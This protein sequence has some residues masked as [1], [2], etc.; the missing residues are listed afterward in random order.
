MRITK[1]KAEMLLLARRILGFDHLRTDCGATQTDGIDVD[2]LIEDSL[3][4]WYLDL[5]D[6]GPAHHLAPAEI[7]VT[8]S[9]PSGIAG[10]T[11]L[12]TGDECRRP[13]TVRMAGWHHETE[14]LPPEESERVVG[15][16]MNRYGAATASHP[17]A[18]RV[19]GG[20]G[21]LAWPDPGEYGTTHITGAVDTGSD[22]YTMDESA[23]STLP[24][25]LAQLKITDYGC[26]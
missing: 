2:T 18:V 9:R 8:A 23:L 17:V 19:P 15:M 3:R 21:I 26:I 12:Q 24:A 1:T 13:L 20:R 22:V 10:G 7:Q 25:W 14:V 6:N 5:L 11:L 16:Q 4:Q